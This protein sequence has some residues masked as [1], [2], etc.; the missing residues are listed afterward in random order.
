MRFIRQFPRLAVALV[1]MVALATSA[2]ASS[3]SEAPGTAKDRLADDTDVYAWVA[4]DAPSAVTFVANWVPLL[5]PNAGPNFYGFDDEA[6]YT[7][8]VDNDGDAVE[9]IWYEFKFT[10]TRQNGGTFLYNTGPIGSLTDG[11]FN[12]RQ[13][14]TVT[15]YDNGTPTVL[16]SGI[17]VPPTNIGPKSTPNYNAL[18]AQ[19][20]TTL[21]D[22][23]KVFAGPRDD[24]FFVDLGSIFDL[25]TIR[26]LP[27]DKGR[28][29]DG[30]GGFNCMTVA[31]GAGPG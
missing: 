3:H 10:T 12:V 27:G 22:G 30:V 11:N 25:L 20:I 26:K 15:R 4:A 6:Y 23:S 1:A 13:T 2:L 31:R 7:I 9:E 16:G 14:Y 28:G 17:P 24:P 8:N 19:A 18:A 29:V 5:E 21:S